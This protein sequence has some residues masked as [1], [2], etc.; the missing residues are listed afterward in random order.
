MPGTS[1]NL[2]VNFAVLRYSWGYISGTSLN[3][4][5]ILLYFA[6]FGDICISDTSLNLG[7]NLL[8]FTPV[9]G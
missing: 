4:G 2:G 6:T 1:L 7:V 8:Y 9:G 5:V 3:L